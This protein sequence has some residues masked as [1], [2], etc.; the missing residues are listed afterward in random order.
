MNFATDPRRPARLSRLIVTRPVPEAQLWAD[1]LRERAWPAHVLP[2]IEIGEPSDAAAL[3]A[4]QDW[5]QQVFHAD[6][7][8]FVSGAAVTHFFAGMEPAQVTSALAPGQALTRFWAPGPATASALQ[9]AGVPFS[10]IDSPARDAPQFDSETLW[11][12]VAAQVRAGAQVLI[13]RGTSLGTAADSVPGS[14]RDWLIR[15]CLAAG[16]RVEA[17]VA[18]ERRA[19]VWSSG[20]QRLAQ[21]AV[22]PDS[23]WLFSSSEA[24]A[25]LQVLLPQAKWQDTFALATHPRIAQSAHAAGFGH[26]VT[27]RPA[28]RDVMLALESAWSHA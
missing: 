23:A 28:L 11:P 18:Y 19:P 27:S 6:A 13:V 24:L 20:Q 16:A 15:Q 8:M 4:L 7:A 10:R 3:T 2:L 5:R 1:A 9:E 22:G 17:C 21:T 26:V 25:N 12:I 14:G